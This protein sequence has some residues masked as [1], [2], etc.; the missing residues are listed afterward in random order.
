MKHYC[1][2][3]TE[4]EIIINRLKQHGYICIA[5]E[6]S[7]NVSG[8]VSC[9]ADVL[10]LK[11]DS[12]SFIVSD[13]QQNNINLLEQKGFIVKKIK[14]SAGYKTESRLNMVITDKTVI[15]NPKTC[16]ADIFNNDKTVIAVNQGYTKCSTIVIDNDNFITEDNGIYT[17]LEKAGKNCLLIAKGYAELQGYNYGF[18]GGAS[19]FL[20]A[21]NTLLFF[22]NIK[23][24]PD[25]IKIEEFCRRCGINTD[26]IKEIPL[27]DIGGFV[28]F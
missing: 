3:N 1:I 18:I 20:S 24:H 14:L 8:P 25:Y 17:A 4:N 13:C 16:A 26:Y 11:T 2:V 9:H 27:Q 15:C 5:T 21:I 12:N 6:K 28:E 10:Y 22:G 7:G 23:T 19:A